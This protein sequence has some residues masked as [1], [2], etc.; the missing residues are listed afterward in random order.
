MNLK[1]LRFHPNFFIFINES[2]KIEKINISFYTFI[3]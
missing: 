3:I 2:K 1:K